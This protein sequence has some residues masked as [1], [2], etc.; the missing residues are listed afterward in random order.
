MYQEAIIRYAKQRFGSDPEF[1]WQKYPDYAVLRNPLS[2]KWFA[3]LLCVPARHLGLSEDGAIW[4]LDLKCAPAL[5]D[6]LRAVKGY[7]PAYHMNK[8]HWI[9]VVLDGTVP[10]DD[11]FALLT[12]SYEMTVK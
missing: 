10:L 6:E 3:L 11:V 1:L 12:D 9:S 8:R 4:L 7:L 5:I 2:G